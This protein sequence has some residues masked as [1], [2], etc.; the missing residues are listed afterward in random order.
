MLSGAV[1]IKIVIV[2]QVLIALIV[3]VVLKL[4]LDRELLRNALEGL[5]AFHPLNNSGISEIVV[6]SAGKVSFDDETRL[7]SVLKEK[8]PAAEIVMLQNT[9]LGGGVIVQ[10]GET[11]FDHS[12]A[13]RFREMFHQA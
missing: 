8:F 9:S 10:C 4:F 6:I 2:L 11:I 3:V 7:K 5:H 12:L 1:L 13:A